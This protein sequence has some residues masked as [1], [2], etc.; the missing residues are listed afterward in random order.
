MRSTAVYTDCMYPRAS[1]FSSMVATL[2]E[3]GGREGPSH[4]SVLHELPS[5]LSAVLLSFS[6]S[7][8]PF[9]ITSG[10]RMRGIVVHQI[11]IRMNVDSGNSAASSSSTSSSSGDAVA[12]NECRSGH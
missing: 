11:G 12:P 2:F 10:L 7:K 4:S 5:L 8:L 1:R 6:S 3:Y 9:G